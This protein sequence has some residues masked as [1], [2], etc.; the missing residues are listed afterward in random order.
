MVPVKKKKSL[1]FRVELP[2]FPLIFNG[3]NRFQVDGGIVLKLF[4]DNWGMLTNTDISS[5][6]QVYVFVG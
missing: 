2:R 4:L 5:L 6:E 3:L 1:H